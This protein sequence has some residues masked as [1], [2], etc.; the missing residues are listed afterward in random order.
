MIKIIG[1]KMENIIEVCKSLSVTSLA[2]LFLSFV[3][4]FLL[5]KSLFD[6]KWNNLYKNNSFSNKIFKTKSTEKNNE[7]NLKTYKK[8]G[9]ILYVKMKGDQFELKI[10]NG[11][12]LIYLI[13]NKKK[14][15]VFRGDKENCINISKDLII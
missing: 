7:H 13:R 9:N 8:I 14:I 11:E 5:L 10:E 12:Y 1:I 3:Y 6:K 4:I 15:E 2:I